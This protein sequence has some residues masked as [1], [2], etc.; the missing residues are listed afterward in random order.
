MVRLVLLENIQDLGVAAAPKTESPELCTARTSHSTP[1]R[2]ARPVYV[3]KEP[4]KHKHAYRARNKVLG[5]AQVEAVEDV[6][7][8]VCDGERKARREQLVAR[9]RHV[10]SETERPR[11]SRCRAGV[12]PGAGIWP[13][14]GPPLSSRFALQNAHTSPAELRC[15]NCGI[16]AQIVEVCC[17][18][19]HMEH[20]W[21]TQSASSFVRPSPVSRLPVRSNVL[22]HV[23]CMSHRKDQMAVSIVSTPCRAR[24]DGL[25]VLVRPKE[26]NLT[27]SVFL[28]VT[29][30]DEKDTTSRDRTKPFATRHPV[31]VILNG[32]HTSRTSKGGASMQRGS[33]AFTDRLN[34]R[35][36]PGSPDTQSWNSAEQWSNIEAVTSCREMVRKSMQSTC[37]R[38]SIGLQIFQV[39]PVRFAEV[40]EHVHLWTVRGT[41]VCG[42][43]LLDGRATQLPRGPVLDEEF[44]FRIF[45]KRAMGS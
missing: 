10:R 24:I 19:E 33:L 35:T 1:L 27:P 36:A 37:G 4:P 34:S 22:G 9:E 3:G 28:G 15:G 26:R 13:S 23:P 39:G 40:S 14:T 2:P 29:R 21:A 16:I 41:N 8:Y 11:P 44:D 32:M 18:L 43:D 42:C 6:W 7:A 12:T 17:D 20:A 5:P 25:Q 38:C 31:T 45:V 30:V